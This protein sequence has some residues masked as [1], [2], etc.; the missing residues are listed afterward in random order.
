MGGFLVTSYKSKYS[1]NPEGGAAIPI[2]IHPMFPPGTMLYDI[3]TNPYP[4]SRVP[5]VRQF[6]LQRD[7]Y[8]IE[9][10]IVTR[11]WTFGTYIHE[12]LA[13][14]MPWISALR[15]GIGPFVKP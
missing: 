5:S 2:R 12:V 14:Y 8:A 4:H 10:P 13:H 11:Q 9:W 7:Y 1:I 15:T 3:N 6:L